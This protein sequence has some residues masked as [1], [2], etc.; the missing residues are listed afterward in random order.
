MN[1]PDH[2][3]AAAG[4]HLETLKWLHPL[5]DKICAEAVI[6]GHIDI[7]QWAQAPQ[8]T[9]TFLTLKA[10]DTNS[11]DMVPRGTPRGS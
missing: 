10:K 7:L 1:V 2:P 9:I 6:A 3:W 4:G 5:D 8:N 11:Q